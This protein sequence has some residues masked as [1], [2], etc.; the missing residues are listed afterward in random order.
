MCPARECHCVPTWPVTLAGVGHRQ[1]ACSR[2]GA[3]RPGRRHGRAARALRTSP[4]PH[5]RAPP[6]A[7]HRQH[8]HQHLPA[9]WRGRRHAAAGGRLGHVPGQERGR[10]SSPDR[11]LERARRLRC[12]RGPAAR[13]LRA[14]PHHQEESAVVTV[15]GAARAVLALNAMLAGWAVQAQCRP[16][17][18]FRR[19]NHCRRQLGTS[20]Q[21]VGQIS[22]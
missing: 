3:G 1:R 6:R 5:P 20:N 16:S 2:H 8:R 18:G 19:R 22:P 10:R 11:P 12:A 9:A 13:T 21:A 4:A 15:L 14:V 17:H 7:G